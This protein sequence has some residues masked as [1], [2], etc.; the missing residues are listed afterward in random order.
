MDL[1]SRSSIGVVRRPKL[2]QE[3]QGK[4][5]GKVRGTWAIGYRDIESWESHAYETGWLKDSTDTW[6]IGVSVLSVGVTAL[7]AT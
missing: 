7:P 2:H 6:E 4:W 1:T 3:R 5:E